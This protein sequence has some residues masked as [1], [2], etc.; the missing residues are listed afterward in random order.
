MSCKPGEEPIDFAKPS[1]E[2]EW[3][4]RAQLFFENQKWHLASQCYEKVGNKQAA[5]VANAY[6][7]REQARRMPTRSKE[8]ARANAFTSAA[9]AFVSCAET[10]NRTIDKKSYFKLGAE[11]YQDGGKQSFAAKIYREGGWAVEAVTLFDELGRFEDIHAMLTQSE[12]DMVSIPDS[13]LDRT[14]LHYI[15]KKKY[16]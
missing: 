9:K 15:S 14:R 13:I 8:L 6:H 4:V 3:A 16:R 12:L 10:T 1:D 2:K 5:A 7:Q 11:C